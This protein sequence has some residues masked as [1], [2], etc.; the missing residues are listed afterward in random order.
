MDSRQ[1]LID[2]LTSMG[3]TAPLTIYQTGLL[4]SLVSLDTKYAV[5]AVL[6]FV[7]GDGFNYLSKKY[8]RKLCE[9]NPVCNRPLFIDG[10]GS[11]AECHSFPIQAAP[12][13]FK[14]TSFGMP[15]GHSHFVSLA[16]T[17]WTLYQVGRFKKST[18]S[19]T[20]TLLVVSMIAI[21]GL[22]VLVMYHRTLI[23]CHNLEQVVV[24]GFLG[25][26]FGFVAYLVAS[27]IPGVDIPH[28]NSVLFGEDN[29]TDDEEEKTAETDKQKE[30]EENNRVEQIRITDRVEDKKLVINLQNYEQDRK[31][32]DLQAINKL[33]RNLTMDVSRDNGGV[34]NANANMNANV[35]INA[36]INAEEDN[37]TLGVLGG[38]GGM[39]F[40]GLMGSVF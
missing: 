2:L 34:D 37:D 25:V 20:R 28:I 35:N 39:G 14:T 23:K 30:T 36:N 38:V 33:S 27:N 9:N 11:V 22:A 21:C 17:F 4:A 19:K 6:A 12:E 8:S 24:G 29:E 18:D 13:S 5:F 31:E 10:T 1:F 7:F 16:A 3:K 26:L 15:S 32:Q 40:R